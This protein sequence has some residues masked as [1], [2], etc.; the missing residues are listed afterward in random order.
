MSED[1]DRS[2]GQT[3]TEAH[4][5]YCVVPC[6]EKMSLGAIG[7]EGNQVFTLPY[8]NLSVVAHACAPQA[9][10]SEE[11][12]AVKAWLLAHQK[13]VET[14]WARYGTVIPFSF[15]VIVK[16]AEE[17]VVSWLKEKYEELE[18]KLVRLEGKAE[19]GVQ[20][21][22]EPK[23]I[24]EKIVQTDAQA[25]ELQRQ[26]G[27]LPE[28]TAYLHAQKLEKLLKQKL[29]QEADRYFKD[30]YQ[31][32]RSCVEDVRVERVRKEQDRQMLANLSCLAEKVAPQRLGE[33]LDRIQALSG[34]S[35]RFTGPWPPYSFVSP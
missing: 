17:R 22:W 26:L 20:I 4:Y 5:V 8:Q 10:V 18:Q 27:C 30:F 29:E 2:S 32:I 35:V 7:L 21:A 28:G 34:F 15:D 16:G 13:V 14:A 12:A 31:R 9:Y 25:R 3:L 24:L 19:Y 23:L 6:G 1:N 11:E 33:E